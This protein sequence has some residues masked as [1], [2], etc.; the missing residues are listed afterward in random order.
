MPNG[1]LKLGNAIAIKGTAEFK[2]AVSN[3]LLT[4]GR[5]PSGVQV[6]EKIEKSGKA[7]TIVEYTGD[8]S[9]AGAA[10]Y[11]DATPAGQPA[12]Q[13]KRPILDASGK[14]VMGTGK[15][16]DT[17]LEFNPKLTL[18]NDQNPADPM[19]ND[20]VLFHEM[21]HGNHHMNATFDGKP[22]PGWS[23]QEEENTISLGSPSEAS[24][25]KE[26]GYKWKR[27]SHGDTFGPNP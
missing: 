23:T 25:L 19:P 11:R 2:A 21:N 3:R 15:G 13:G 18:P 22:K 9:F 6:L 7:M 20:A 12:F 17:K 24:Y 4:I 26:R 8:N 1:D 16:S 14:Q 27:T 5:F 10:N